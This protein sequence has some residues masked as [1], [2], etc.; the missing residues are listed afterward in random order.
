MFSLKSL[1]TPAFLRRLGGAGASAIADGIMEFVYNRDSAYWTG[2]FPFIPTIEPL[3]PLDDFLVLGGSVATWLLGAW[4]N[5][6]VKEVGEGAT[7]YA[8]A[9]ILHHIIHRSAFVLPLAAPAA[10]AEVPPTV[11]ERLA[12]KGYT[13]TK[14]VQLRNGRYTPTMPGRLGYTPTA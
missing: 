14:A 8:T 2:R 5:E 12:R 10:A 13:P 3:P 9:M 11:A 1:F 7:I 6:K 4:K